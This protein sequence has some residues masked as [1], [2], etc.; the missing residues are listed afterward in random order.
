MIANERQY[1]VTRKKL[2]E[3]QELNASVERG[4][5]GDEGFRDFQAEAL[6][7]KMGDLRD[8]IAEYERR[9]TLLTRESR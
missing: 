6:E 2:G 8:E 5:A 9:G 1:F 7:A 3:L 4:T